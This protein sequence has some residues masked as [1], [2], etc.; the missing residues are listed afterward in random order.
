MST[1][2]SFALADHRFSLFSQLNGRWQVADSLPLPILMSLV[3]QL[4]SIVAWLSCRKFD[5]AE[6]SGLPGLE[7]RCRGGLH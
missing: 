3:M 2:N 1:V 5:V 4:F 7:P 6:N